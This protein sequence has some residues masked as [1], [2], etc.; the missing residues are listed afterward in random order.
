MVLTLSL[1]LT[2]VT[3]LK[4]MC[5]RQTVAGTETQV[6][7]ETKTEMVVTVGVVEGQVD[8]HHMNIGL[9]AG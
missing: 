7:T 4:K 2:I 9:L 6:P 3:V 5:I 8:L 1:Q